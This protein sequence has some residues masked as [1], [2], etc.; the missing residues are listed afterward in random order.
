MNQENEK[1][2]PAGDAFAIIDR[3]QRVRPLWINL[4]PVWRNQDGSLTFEV[5]AEPLAWR[6]AET[7]RRVQIRFRDEQ[8]HRRRDDDDDDDGTPFD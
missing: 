4:G 2:T 8:G 1:R 6:R 7:E 5:T 3:G